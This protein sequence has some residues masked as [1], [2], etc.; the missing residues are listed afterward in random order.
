MYCTCTI[1]S[2]SLLLS[3]VSPPSSLQSP[4]CPSLL[5][6]D[7]SALFTPPLS[8]PASA[9]PSTLPT[10]YTLGLQLH[11]SPFTPR[12]TT[13]HNTQNTVHNKRQADLDYLSSG[14]AGYRPALLPCSDRHPDDPLD[15]PSFQGRS[16]ASRT[17]QHPPTTC[18]HLAIP[19]T[20]VD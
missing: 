10:T 12:T 5:Y 3:F 9:H 20:A 18:A 4:S 19:S 14:S 6:P 16:S 1:K 13:H 7:S 11:H 15:I 17:V 2:A 8:P